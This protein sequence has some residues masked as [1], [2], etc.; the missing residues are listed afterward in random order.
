MLDRIDEYTQ[1]ESNIIEDAVNGKFSLVTWKL[2]GTF[3]NGNADHCCVCMF[4]GKP[5]TE[6]STGERIMV[7]NDVVNTMAKA[8][9]FNMPR[10]IDDVVLVTNPIETDCQTFRL[11]TDESESTLKVTVKEV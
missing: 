10:F 11:V 1:R 8:E 9:G 6:C 7:N 3:I 2:F 5:Y 4:N